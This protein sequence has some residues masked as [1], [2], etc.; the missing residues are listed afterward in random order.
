LQRGV[1]DGRR[2]PL[3]QPQSADL[4]GEGQP[5]SRHGVEDPLGGGRLVLGGADGS[6]GGH[7]QRLE[8]CL[9]A[10][11]RATVPPGSGPAPHIHERTD[12]TFYVVNGELEFL[13]GN[14]TFTASTGDVV[15]LPRGNVHRFHNPGVQPAKLVFV[16]TPGGAEG[17]FVEGGDE[18]ELGVQVQPWGPERI[19]ERMLGLLA[20][21]DTGLRR[22][23]RPAHSF[24]RSRCSA[25]GKESGPRRKVRSDC[26]GPAVVGSR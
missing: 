2:L 3:Q 6:G 23:S 4:V 8:A 1:E 12:E 17:L 24:D 9:L 14:K 13:N 26:R 7:R 16:Y 11:A 5:E 21:Y 10:R 20:K 25:V 15:F 22:S 19:D 18:P